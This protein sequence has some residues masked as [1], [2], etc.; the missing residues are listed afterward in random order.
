MNKSGNTKGTLLVLG[1]VLRAANLFSICIVALFMTPFLIKS[2]GDRVYG[3][4]MLVGSVFGFYDLLDLG[5]TAAVR[6]FL[7]K[8]LGLKNYE[9]GNQVI[10]TALLV[11]SIIGL[12]AFGITVIVAFF[13]RYFIPD[14]AEAFLFRNFLLITGVSVSLMFVIRT[15]YGVLESHLRYDINVGVDLLN[16][17]LR[18]GLIILFLK[19]GYGLIAIA[20]IMLSVN[21]FCHIITIIFTKAVAKYMKFSFKYF[22]RK[23]LK[24]FFGYSIYSFLG[25]VSSRI[26]NDIDNFVIAGFLGVGFVTVYSI[27]A[28]LAKYF[29]QLVWSSTGLMTPIFSQYEAV[30]NF[31]AIREKYVFV[32]KLAWCFSLIIGGNI[33]LLG[34]P[35]ILRWVGPEYIAAYPL[36]VILVV[37]SALSLTNVTGI[38]LVYGISRHKFPSL[39]SL[40]GSLTNLTLSIILVRF[41]GLKGV[42]L[43]TAIPSVFLGLF[44]MPVYICHVIQFDHKKYYLQV[45][46]PCFLLTAGYLFF[47]RQLFKFI[48]AP[49]YFN[50]VVCGII[51]TVCYACL[52]IPVLFDKQERAYLLQAVPL[53]KIMIWGHRKRRNA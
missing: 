37:S 50:V 7:S 3:M 2:L 8:E 34:K 33:I 20:V 5:L 23:K 41:M 16:L 15:F 42:A 48:V 6:R 1:S 28:R 21:V 40:F 11:F 17:L 22:N 12:A 46:A 45:A 31:G 27:A 19:K 29:S 44:V 53:Q 43:G 36:L 26:G 9:E 35:F 24:I 51:S 47:V 14:P 30:G 18:T 4:W 25:Q 39:V 13:S 10:N 52:A 38:N 49:S 32:S